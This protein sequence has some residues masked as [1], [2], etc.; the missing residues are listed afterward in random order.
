MNYKV[1]EGTDENGN[2]CTFKVEIPEQPKEEPKLISKNEK[3]WWWKEYHYEYRG[4]KLVEIYF[5]DSPEFVHHSCEVFK[6]KKR[7][8]QFDYGN[9]VDDA[10]AYIDEVLL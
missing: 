3:L 8:I 7:L 9:C 5:D 4:Y 2:P 1:V 6:G 10:V